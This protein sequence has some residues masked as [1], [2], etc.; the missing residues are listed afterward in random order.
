MATH[1]TVFAWEIPWTEETGRLQS[2]GSQKSW[3]PLTDRTCTHA[4]VL[5]KAKHFPF[6][7]IGV[8]LASFFFFFPIFESMLASDNQDVCWSSSHL[9]STEFQARGKRREGR[10]KS[11]F[12]SWVCFL[13]GFSC[14]S[15]QWLLLTFF[16]NFNWRIIALQCRV[17]FCYT[18]MWT[19][20]K[21]WPLLAVWR[22]RNV[23]SISLL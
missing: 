6:A 9:N 13:K 14:N 4:Q 23:S 17:G 3:T 18:T 19:C 16:S 21:Y 20:P 8:N 15:N 10:E 1:S 11:R 2:M 22:V 7:E 5:L 12:S